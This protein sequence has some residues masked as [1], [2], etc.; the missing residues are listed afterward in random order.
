MPP[1]PDLAPELLQPFVDIYTELHRHPELSMK[2]HRTAEVI[3]SVL[4]DSGIE[5][6]RCAPTGVV[7][8]LRNGEGPVVAFRADIDGL[9]ILELTGLPHASTDTAIAEDGTVVPT[10]HGCGHD[11]HVASALA[12]AHILAHNR[13][14]WV[15]TIVFIFQPG[16]EMLAGSAAMIE[17]GLWDRAPRPEIMLGQ[18]LGA[19]AAGTVQ[20]RPG[21][22]MALS[23]SW[24]VVVHGRGAHGAHPD[25]AI[26]PIVTAAYMITRLQAVVSRHS[27]PL[28]PIVVTVGSFHA[29]ASANT[30]PAEAEFSLNIRTPS[31]G[32]R[33][34]VIADVRQIIIAEAT[35]AGCET[36]TITEISRSPRCF[37]D[38][39]SLA[40]VS[41]GL[42]SE[43]GDDAVIVDRPR[44]MASEDFGRLGDSIGVPTVFWWFGAYEASRFAAME[45]PVPANHSPQFGPDP[46]PA[47]TTGV[48]AALA[49]IL[50]YSRPNRQPQPKAP[51]HR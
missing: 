29:G 39:P 12:A 40:L 36:P 3:E 20:T 23:D 17:D 10:M 34:W 13:S 4:L 1:L 33:E 8:I 7:A 32:V 49:S 46:V 25:K 27:N 11:A 35:A 2:E 51:D 22:A 30:I 6:F 37:N 9:P 14:A 31:E 24:K 21:D 50:V 43:L 5:T 47:I 45:K 19:F 16:E 41:A 26:D 18:H 44:T 28:D 48:R 15:G 42:R 38:P